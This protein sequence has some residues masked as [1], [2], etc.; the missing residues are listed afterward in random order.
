LTTS[1]DGRVSDPLL[2]R[3]VRRKLAALRHVE[4][5]T[6]NVAMICR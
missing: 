5:L 3:E 2:E 4:E 1:D 6:D